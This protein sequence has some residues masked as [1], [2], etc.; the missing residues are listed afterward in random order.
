MEGRQGFKNFLDDMGPRPSGKTLD[1][2]NP[3]GHYEPTNCKWAT[4]KEQRNNRR[5]QLWPNG[6]MPRVE[7]VRSMKARIKKFEAMEVRLREE[8]MELGG[9]YA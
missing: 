7:G 8:A 6:N 3:Q 1:R 2:I 4:R 9:C 5:P